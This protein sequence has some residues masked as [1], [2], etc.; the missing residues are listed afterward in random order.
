MWLFNHFNFGRNYVVLKSKSSCILLN[1]NINI[2][3]NETE[4][5]IENPTH[6]FGETKLG[7]SSYKNRKLKVKLQWVRAREKKREHFVSFILSEGNIFNICNLSQCILCWIHLQKIHTLTNQ[8]TLLHT[9]LLLVFKIVE[10]LHCIKCS[11]S[12]LF[13]SAF[14]SIRTEYREIRSISPYLVRMWEN[15]DQNI[16]EYGHFSCSASMYP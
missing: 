5:K 9:F 14:S 3:K 1:K 16:S 12:E 15:A 11:Y 6:S 10:S 7:F 4:S 8:K 2:N 13:L